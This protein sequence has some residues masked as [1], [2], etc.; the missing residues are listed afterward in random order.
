MDGNLTSRGTI[1]ALE[2]LLGQAREGQ[3]IGVAFVGVLRGR[4]PI[5][6]FSG[7]VS[8]DPLFAMGAIQRLNEDLLEHAKARRY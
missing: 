5:K 1:K 8:Q 6:G 7:H 4:R 2:D 3:L